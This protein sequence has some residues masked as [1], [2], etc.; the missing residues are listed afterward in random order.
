[1]LRKGQGRYGGPCHISTYTMDTDTSIWGLGAHKFRPERWIRPD[2]G[3]SGRSTRT[4]HVPVLREDIGDTEH[5]LM[6]LIWFGGPAPDLVDVLTRTQFDIILAVILLHTM[7]K[8]L[9]QK[10]LLL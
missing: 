7:A 9:P 2:G 1:M 8:W 6:T 4:T 10:N 3:G 5:E